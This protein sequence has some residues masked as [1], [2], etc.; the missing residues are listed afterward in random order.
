MQK[1]NPK[2]SNDIFNKLH[3]QKETEIGVVKHWGSLQEGAW[4]LEHFGEKGVWHFR[5][6]KNMLN[7]KSKQILFVFSIF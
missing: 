2:D 4:A 1:L 3:V 5:K 7:L 6:E